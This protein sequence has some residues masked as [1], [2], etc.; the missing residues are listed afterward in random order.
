MV[1]IHGL[2]TRGLF[3]GYKAS[4]LRTGYKRVVCTGKASII[5]MLPPQHG[6]PDSSRAERTV[7]LMSLRWAPSNTSPAASTAERKSRLRLA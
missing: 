2:R 1:C 4:G 3:A 6:H 5:L 7:C